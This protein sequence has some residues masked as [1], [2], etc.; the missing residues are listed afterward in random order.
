[1]KIITTRTV[2]RRNRGSQILLVAQILAAEASLLLSHWLCRLADRWRNME[3]DYNKKI[4]TLFKCAEISGKGIKRWQA[5][6]TKT[7]MLLSS[8]RS[9]VMNS[10]ISISN[11]MRRQ[12]K[13]SCH[14]RC[15]DDD[16]LHAYFGMLKRLIIIIYSYLKSCNCIR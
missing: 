4:I 7:Q 5:T 11:S 1:M 13:F 9:G 15:A 8:N 10:R 3:R 14:R 16:F 12:K 2:G 6:T